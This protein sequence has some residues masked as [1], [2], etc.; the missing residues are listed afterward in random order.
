M[1][2]RKTVALIL[3]ALCMSSAFVAC[4]KKDNTP[5]LG[6]LPSALALKKAERQL[7]E[8]KQ[9]SVSVALDI[10]GK[11]TGDLE[12]TAILGMD[13]DVTVY[14]LENSLAWGAELAYDGEQKTDKLF[15]SNSGVG[16]YLEDVD[17]YESVEILPIT[18]PTLNKAF[19]E[20]SIA[21]FDSILE[22]K[23]DTFRNNF[24]L[25]INN[26]A[27]RDKN[28]FVLSTTLE[29]KSFAENMMT[30]FLSDGAV[31]SE[32]SMTARLVLDKDRGLLGFSVTGRFTAEIA[33]KNGN[34]FGRNVQFTDE[35]NV[36]YSWD[37]VGLSKEE[38]TNLPQVDS[39]VYPMYSELWTPI[40]SRSKATVSSFVF[41]LDRVGGQLY[42]VVELKLKYRDT[43]W[44]FVLE[45]PASLTRVSELNFRIRDYLRTDS[46]GTYDA[47]YDFVEEELSGV[48]KF[49]W[50][51][52]EANFKAFKMPATWTGGY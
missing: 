15:S 23:E 4:D 51:T 42:Y 26:K 7:S 45:S 22:S 49:N 18:A 30:G 38:A 28:T 33:D 14:A 52:K 31:V 39:M 21:L 12:D 43:K 1:N 29:D 34:C 8:A 6:R 11:N 2:L 19:E 37:L 13:G 40:V 46:E 35:V 27:F 50:N 10:N 47:E 36:E 44:T 20:T 32:S 24:I 41:K 16:R 17:T 3:G 25:T 9:A 48:V 5:S